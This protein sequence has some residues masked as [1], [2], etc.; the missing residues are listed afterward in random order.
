[1]TLQL[2]YNNTMLTVCLSVCLS[3]CGM[4]VVEDRCWTVEVSDLL[5][6]QIGQID[7]FWARCDLIHGLDPEIN[8]FLPDD[9][10]TKGKSETHTQ[11][12][13]HRERERERERERGVCVW[14][15]CEG[16]G[17]HEGEWSGSVRR[18]SRET[19]Q[20]WELRVVWGRL[21]Q[22]TRSVLLLLLPQYLCLIVTWPS[23]A[24]V[25][26]CVSVICRST[27]HRCQFPPELGRVH[28]NPLPPLPSPPLS[29][30]L[31]S[32]GTTFS[33]LEWPLTRISMSQHF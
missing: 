21:C 19:R 18:S 5:I 30:P 27:I 28:G 7:N 24:E 4:R 2:E 11:T 29:I 17:V 31:L 16:V 12:D 20:L 14:L 9:L 8:N 10:S 26:C 1:M 6:G 23:L 25:C 15:W 3:V 13:R 22:W 33:D 32:N